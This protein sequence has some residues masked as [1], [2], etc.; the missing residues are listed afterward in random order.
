MID[1]PEFMSTCILL[2]SS[3]IQVTPVGI[4]KPIKKLLKAKVPDMSK[5]SDISDYVTK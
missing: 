4:T 5:Y 1:S 2:Y 3:N